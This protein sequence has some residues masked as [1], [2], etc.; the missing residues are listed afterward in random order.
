MPIGIIVNSLCVVVGGILGTFAGKF[1][2]ARLKL[3]LPMAFSLGAMA[4]G[5][6]NII[7][8]NC[9]PAV[10]LALLLGTIVGVLLDIEKALR[11]CGKWIG[12]KVADRHAK[13]EETRRKQLEMFSIAAI[14][15][16]ASA[17]GLYGS[18][19][20]A[21]TGDHSLLYAKSVLDVFSNAIFAATA[22]M[23]VVLLGIPMFFIFMATYAC[24]GLLAPYTTPAMFADF[25]CCGGLLILAT[26]FRMAEMKVFHVADM[27]PALALVMPIS[28]LWSL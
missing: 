17:T 9:L 16:C 24:A 21:V 5:I 15:F 10:I 11:T 13:D 27:L 26:G 12:A 28:Y 7:K 19:Q 3:V 18:F 14:V 23:S 25:A 4:M 6:T 2:S 20:S 22:G 1:I 8:V